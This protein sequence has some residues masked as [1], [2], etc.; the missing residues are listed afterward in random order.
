MNREAS[1]NAE[2]IEDCQAGRQ[3]SHAQELVN[4]LPYATM[5]VLGT[6]I[7]LTGFESLVWKWIAASAYL[8]Y[9]VMGALWII[10]FVCPY[11]RYWNTRA[12]PCGYGHVAAR[13]RE[14]KDYDRFKEKFK[15]HI[16]VIVPLWF[17]P[18]LVGISV[19]ERSFSWALLILLVVFAVD[20]F[21]ILPLFS[22]KH[23]CA[24][25]P[26]KDS[27]PWMARKSTGQ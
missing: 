15:K 17:I 24:G 21:V 16:P 9:G 8:A 20:A 13:L 6:A 19:I 2:S 25:C 26:Q 10:V 11:C 22:T 14:K 7:F 5:T 12:C 18:I 23:G 27:C 1:N 4:N 3:Y